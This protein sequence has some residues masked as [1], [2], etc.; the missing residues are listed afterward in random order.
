MRKQTSDL[1][2]EDSDK[3]P[4]L[5]NRDAEKPFGGEAERVL[6]VHG[7]HIVEPVEIG[8]RLQVCLVLDQLFGAAVEE[9]DVGINALDD[10]TIKLKH[11]AKHAVGCRVLGPEVEGEI[12]D[13]G[14]H[15]GASCRCRGN[16]G[17]YQEFQAGPLQ[18]KAQ[19]LKNRT[20][21]I[22]LRIPKLVRFV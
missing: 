13:S 3:L 17:P 11:K 20:A 1:G 5:G 7:R 22:S 6:L 9:A 18:N 21:L 2:I 16:V 4:P 8:Q 15:G 10:L 14:F 12:A 19:A